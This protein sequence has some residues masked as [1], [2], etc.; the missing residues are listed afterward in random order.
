MKPNSELVWIENTPHGRS[1]SVYDIEPVRPQAP[2][3]RGPQLLCRYFSKEEPQ[4]NRDLYNYME[5]SGILD[6]ELER[7][8]WMKVYHRI[9]E[10]LSLMPKKPN[11]IPYREELLS[12][13]DTP[14]AREYIE[15]T[16]LE[17]IILY[18]KL[19][20][21]E[22]PEDSGDSAINIMLDVQRGHYRSSS[23]KVP[24]S[25]HSRKLRISTER[26][27]KEIQHRHQVIT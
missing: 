5:S 17:Q 10:L 27:Y 6:K 12:L 22:K 14:E 9:L 23:D 8:R 11:H 15:E 2:A 7:V 4:F 3:L 18:I 26:A 25:S 13:F 21:E 24:H 19:L 20:V 16:T 1:M